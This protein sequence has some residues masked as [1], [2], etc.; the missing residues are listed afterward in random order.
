MHEP[1]A[2]ERLEEMAKAFFRGKVLCAAVQ[3]GVPDALEGGGRS[4]DE[5]AAAVGARPEPLGRLLR[6]LASMGIVVET[7]PARFEL[8]DLG[9][10]LCSAA[11]DSV[12]A[13]VEFW[14]DLIADQWNYL[15]E[16]VRRG[17]MAEIRGALAQAEQKPRMMAD[18][19]RT[20]A[21]FHRCFAESPPEHHEGFAAAY[22]FSRSRVVADLGGGGGGLLASI[23]SAHPHLRGVLVDLD[24]AMEGARERIAAAGLA[25]RC[26]V[27]VGDLL[28]GGVP[29]DADTYLMKHVLHIF[30]DDEA[31]RILGHCRDAMA[32]TDRLLVLEHVIP[33]RVDR[34]DPVVE[35]ILMDDLNMLTVTGGAERSEA[36]WHALL[37]SAGLALERVL[38]ATGTEVRIVEA[39]RAS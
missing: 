34:A 20:R 8:S 37:D 11:P 30:D 35:S 25:D 19:A 32:P 21:L 1:G 13:T 5:V 23:L 7:T 29:V 2:R 9:R 15:A 14:G 16:C 17:S 31:R 3:L 24:G 12:S 38:R 18:P 22:D 28:Q 10:P 27:Q 36:A 6:T 26:T 4:L 33:E 39:R